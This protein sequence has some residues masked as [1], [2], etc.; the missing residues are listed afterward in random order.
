MTDQPGKDPVTV[1]PN[2]PDDLKG[3]NTETGKKSGKLAKPKKLV[4]KSLKKKGRRF[5]LKWKKYKADAIEIYMK[6]ARGN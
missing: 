1:T 2:P 3:N 6:K 4:F 5:V